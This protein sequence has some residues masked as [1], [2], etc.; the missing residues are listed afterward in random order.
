MQFFS[1]DTP[2]HYGQLIS[3]TNRFAG[4]KLGLGIGTLHFIDQLNKG[5]F[6]PNNRLEKENPGFQPIIPKPPK[7][8][9]NHPKYT[10][11]LHEREFIHEIF[12]P[13][14]TLPNRNF[15]YGGGYS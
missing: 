2:L 10:P 15:P 4:E 14:E 13:G 11:F 6:S 9:Q 5:T 3:P 1:E 12:N 8:I 7:E